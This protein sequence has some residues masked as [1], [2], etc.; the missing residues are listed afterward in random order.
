MRP[1]LAISLALCGLCACSSP[2]G[3]APETGD[4][5]LVNARVYTVDEA[6][7]LAEAVVFRGDSIIYVGDV[8]GA[9]KLIGGATDVRD[10]GGRLMLPG[11]VEA[12]MHVM[13]AGRSATMLELNIEQSIEDW[14]GAVE[15]YA[16]RNPELPAIVGYGFIASAFGQ[17]G[18][19]R[20]LL[21]AVVPDRPVLIMDE[22][23]HTAWANTAALGALGVTRDTPDPVPGFSYYKRDPNGDATGYLLEDVAVSAFEALSPVD[24]D[25]V[26]AGL[27]TVIDIMNSQGITTAFDASARDFDP[28]TIKRSLAR[29]Q[30]SGEL[31]IRVF[32]AAAVSASE[33]AD[34]AV[35]QAELWRREVKGDGFH[36]NALKI[37]NDGTIEAR[38]AAM[39]EDYQGDPGNAGQTVFSEDQLKEMITK[40]AARN[41]DVHVHALGDRAVHEAL[42]A[43]E[44]AREL[45]P[46]ST[47]R[48]TLIHIEVIADQDL[49]RFGELGVIAQ[50]SPL[51]FSYDDY[52]EQFVS[53]NQFRRYWRV[54]SLEATGA[55]LAYGSDFPATGLGIEGMRPLLNMEIGHTRQMPG[56]PD[57]PV[58]PLASERLSL[59][60][61][62]RGYTINGAYMLHMEDE[63]GSIEVGKKADLVV[64]DRNIF[65]VDPY[66]IHETK[67]LMT[68][69]NG[70]VVFER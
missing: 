55:R 65:E 28:L 18:P 51:W 30:D 20:E 35:D 33:Q 53:E 8:A 58:Q 5:A 61:L 23:W 42:N 2:N 21:D 66:T 69:M 4:L 17:A 27:E 63:I 45:H 9:R 16:A 38:T 14:T 48:Y 56:E 7:P 12:H 54:R 70:N 29:V 1:S 6:N 46:E 50:T 11:F 32:G 39:F 57:A 24:E 3:N 26:V 22:G 60:S 34:T 41:L 64:L 36:Y 25:V 49:P 44:V 10:L 37:F 40:A 15:T 43:I 62:I 13:E 59:E 47:N 52:G 67:V 68:L 19:T 31:S